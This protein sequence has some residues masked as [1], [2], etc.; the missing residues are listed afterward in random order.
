[1]GLTGVDDATVIGFISSLTVTKTIDSNTGSVTP[2]FTAASTVFDYLATGE[3]I[4]LTYTIRIDDK[5]GG[6]DTADFDVTITGT[7]DAPVAS[8][9]VGATTE[10]ASVTVDVIANDSDVDGTDVISLQASSVSIKSMTTTPGGATITVGDADVSQSGNDV[11][12]NPGTDF[13]FLAAGETAAVVIDYTVTDDDGT[14]LTDTSTLTI[15]VTGTNDAPTVS[16]LPAQVTFTEDT[17]DNFDLSAASFGDAE[18]DALTV[19]LTASEGA[20]SSLADGIGVGVVET[21]VSGTVITLAGTAAAI[22]TYLDTAT[23]IEYTPV[24]DAWGTGIATVNV[25]ADD[26][27]GATALGSVNIDVTGVNDGGPTATGLPASITTVEDTPGDVDLGALSFSDVDGDV[28]IV[29]LTASDGT[30]EAPANGSGVGNGVTAALVSAA[31]QVTLT[32]LADDINTYLDTPSNI[33]YTGAQDVNGIINPPATITVVANDSAGSGDVAIGSVDVFISLVNDAPTITGLVSSAINENDAGAIVDEFDV[34]DVDNASGLTFAVLDENGLANPTGFEV[35]AVPPTNPGEV[36]TYQLKLQDGLSLDHDIDPI[37]NLIV[38]V[39]DGS[40]ANNVTT[41]AVTVTVNKVGD[42]IVL[43]LNGDGVDLTAA[44]VFD[45]DNDGTIENINWAGPEDGILAVDLDGSGAIEDGNEVFSEVFNEQVFEDSLA[46]L[47]SLDSNGDGI[48]DANDAEFA[49]IVVWQ[50]ANSD[51]VSQSGELQSLSQ[52][53]IVSVD[54]DAA[55]TDYSSN[56]NN[57]FAE[58]EFL[59][60]D[61]TTGA[62]AGVGFSSLNQINGTSESDALLGTDGNDSL[63]GGAGADFLDGGLGFDL[64]F[65]GEGSDTFQITDTSEKPSLD[66]ILDFEAGVDVLDLEAIL[67][68]Y[69]PGSSDEVQIT[70]NGGNAEVSVNG[71]TVAQLNGVTAGSVIDVAYDSSQAAFEFTVQTGGVTV[72]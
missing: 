61:G 8:V 6:T 66:Q 11:T 62:Y 14:P 63:N 37:V 51:G 56:G 1:D 47:A 65:G 12:F 2:T 18:G 15:T 64:L 71:E 54:L 50:D 7:N 25:T 60:A 5:D 30:F 24:A 38:Q 31:T 59:Q 45:I 28:I 19:T 69:Q 16:A 36:G 52:H 70:E 55:R 35:V 17:S 34:G 22:N 10:N 53:G 42:P 72:T 46:A 49:N 20:F 44:S 23:N 48:I 40:G 67:G 57:V 3:T 26:G 39:N 13:D 68:E 9:D 21:L 27:T 41:Q 43:D 32:G 33:Q 4:K 58:G 29:T